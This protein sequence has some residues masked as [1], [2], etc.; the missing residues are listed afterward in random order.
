MNE[1]DVNKDSPVPLYYQIKEKLKEEIESGTLEPHDRL[2]SERDLEKRYGVSRMTARRALTELESDGYVYR[3]QGKGSY[4]AEPKLRQGLLEL[5]GFSEDM[6]NRRMS[7]GA[8]VLEQKTIEPEKAI[9]RK[10]KVSPD[11]KVFL[12]Q[13]VRT[14]ESEPLAIETTHLR[15]ELCEGIEEMDFSDRSLYSTLRNE[16]DLTLSRAKQSVESTL[17]DDFEATELGV[18][19]GTPMLTT[20]RTTFISDGET[21]IE[22]AR[23]TYRGDRYKLLVELE[24]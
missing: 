6:K 2:P 11:D 5:T 15:Y 18:P 3:E 17:A 20:E 14:A 12:L 16:Y 19:E 10:L 23:S 9:A 24:G 13:R 21:P 7:P 22:Y 1:S 8:Q 4:V